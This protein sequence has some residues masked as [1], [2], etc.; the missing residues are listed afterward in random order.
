MTL[1][2][3]VLACLSVVGGLVNTP[4]RLGLEHF[5]EPSFEGVHIQRL[6]PTG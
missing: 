4:F 3:I 6:P 5:L 2:L 1:P